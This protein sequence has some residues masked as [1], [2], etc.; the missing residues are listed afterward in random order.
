MSIAILKISNCLDCPHH[1]VI[2][3]GDPYDSFCS[4]DMAVVCKLTPNNTLN[5]ESVWV[6][7]RN[8]F[9]GVSFSCRPYNL[10]KESSVPNWCPLIEK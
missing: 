1:K 6:V 5:L 9:R 8:K 3:D 4:D 2:D 7:D 10:R